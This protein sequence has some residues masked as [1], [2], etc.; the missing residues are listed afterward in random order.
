MEADNG[1][2]PLDTNRLGDIN[3][4]VLP[5]LRAQSSTEPDMQ[6]AAGIAGEVTL[7]EHVIA[8]TPRTWEFIRVH[9]A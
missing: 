5:A 2:L 1:A 9:S 4:D 3:V 8:S 7:N 6:L